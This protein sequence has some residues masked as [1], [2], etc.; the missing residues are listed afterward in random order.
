MAQ[1]TIRRRQVGCDAEHDLVCGGPRLVVPPPILRKR[2]AESRGFSRL[3]PPTLKEMRTKLG[4]M[5]N[6][7][8]DMDGHKAHLLLQGWAAFSINIS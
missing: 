6:H 2:R 1:E 5:K 3:F 4:F 8:A 7:W